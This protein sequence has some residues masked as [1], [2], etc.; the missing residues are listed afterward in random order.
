LLVI[1]LNTITR[2][3][4]RVMTTRFP[5]KYL[6]M[7]RKESCPKQRNCIVIMLLNTV[8]IKP[9]ITMNGFNWNITSGKR[10]QAWYIKKLKNMSRQGGHYIICDSQGIHSFS[11]SNYSNLFHLYTIFFTNMSI[12]LITV[13]DLEK[14][15]IVRQAFL[16]PM[17]RNRAMDF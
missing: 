3:L 13:A 11:Q 14:Q 4:T 2:D 16:L 9:N 6:I 7:V 8:F 17:P 12:K 15:R 1:L 10:H 5:M